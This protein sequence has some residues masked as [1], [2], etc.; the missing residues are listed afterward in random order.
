MVRI[1]NTLDQAEGIYVSHHHSD[2]LDAKALH[3]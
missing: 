1:D 2:H 3:G